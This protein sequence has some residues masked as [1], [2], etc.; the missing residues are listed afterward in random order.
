MCAFA[1]YGRGSPM[2]VGM[3]TR[4]LP[5][6]IAGIE[7]GG[8]VRYRGILIRQPIQAATRTV[9]IVFYRVG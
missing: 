1:V 6:A 5:G 8:E 4:R 9:A 3:D 2:V 7:G